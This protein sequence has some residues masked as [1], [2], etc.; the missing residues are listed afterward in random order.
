[1]PVPTVACP[2]HATER[3][4]RDSLRASARAEDASG[5]L[6]R[7]AALLREAGWF[8]AALPVRDGGADAGRGGVT[9]RESVD[10]FI[11]LAEVNLAAARLYEGH[12]NAIGLVTHYAEPFTQQRF[13]QF[14]RG[15]GISGVWGADGPAPV[16]YDATARTL[17]GAKR[18]ASG[19][20]IV[21]R[22]LITARDGDTTRL[23]IVDVSDSA[24]ADPLAWRMGG[25]R[26]TASGGYDFGAI[27]HLEFVGPPDVYTREPLFLGGVWRIA[28]VTLGG[29]FGLL[30][31][32]R[33]FL[34]ARDRLMHPAQIARLAPL[35]VRALAAREAIVRAAA[36]A[37]GPEGFADPDRAAAL[38][39]GV[40]LLSETLGQDA[41]AAVERSVGLTHFEDGNETGRIA[42]DLAT[43]MRQA[44]G[45]ALL[46]RAGGHLLGSAG[47][48]AELQP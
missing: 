32:A 1:M 17:S 40:R 33:A 37:E 38:S 29:V 11:A 8:V 43:Y 34:S 18:F 31:A 4:D 22:A 30:E 41:I 15:G 47:R 6:D 3:F 9:A 19:L 42:R 16:R 20:G 7:S 2:L 5:T 45:D 39:I 44:A 26:A 14:V 35:V 13:V 23:A 10:R 27:A 24:R 36:F 46:E 21:G 48:L 12:V 25:M 28:A